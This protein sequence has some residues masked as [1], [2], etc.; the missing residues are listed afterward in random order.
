MTYADLLREY[1]SFSDVARELGLTRAAVSVWRKRGV[2]L[3]RQFE[4]E[5]RTKGRLRAARPGDKEA[6]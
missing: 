2:P 6:R 1:G 3:S 4:L 5:V